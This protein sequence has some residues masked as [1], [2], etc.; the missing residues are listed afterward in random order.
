MRV[1]T[2]EHC[3]TNTTVPMGLPI[4]VHSTTNTTV[5]ST[6]NTFV[7]IRVPAIYSITVQLLKFSSYLQKTFESVTDVI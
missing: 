4:K 6:T 1:P 3:T 7:L 2:K 5:H